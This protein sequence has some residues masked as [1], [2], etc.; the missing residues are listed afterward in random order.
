[1]D[2]QKPYL[3][4]KRTFLAYYY[5]LSMDNM[6][7]EQHSEGTPE[8]T[9]LVTP[10]QVTSKVPDGA[11]REG[12]SQQ[13]QS[14][15]VVQEQRMIGMSEDLLVAG[16]L[17]QVVPQ[18]TEYIKAVTVSRL[19]E[20]FWLNENL[21]DTSVKDIAKH[22]ERIVFILMGRRLGGITGQST[23][24]EGEAR[25]DL[26]MHFLKLGVLDPQDFEKA[27]FSFS[28]HD[29][30]AEAF[31]AHFLTRI[32]KSGL[33]W[34]RFRKNMHMESDANFSNEN[35]IFSH[36]DVLEKYGSV[37]GP[38]LRIVCSTD[39]H[40]LALLIAHGACNGGPGSPLAPLLE[41][42]SAHGDRVAF[43]SAPN[44]YRSN[45][46]RG[47]RCSQRIM[48]A[49]FYFAQAIL[50]NLGNLSDRYDPPHV[51]LEKEMKEKPEDKDGEG[52]KSRMR[53]LER[54][55]QHDGR[56]ARCVYGK[57][58]ELF[59]LL[60]AAL[61]SIRESPEWPD[62]KGAGQWNDTSVG[63]RL[64]AIDQAITKLDLSLE[65]WERA[66]R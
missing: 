60:P 27:I 64:E 66:E 20:L 34:P 47:V 45:W 7:S 15:E 32:M 2:V 1:M 21:N 14:L 49:T 48:D 57:G 11:V 52:K 3:L 44:P 18:A 37:D 29:G 9:A 65:H 33:P 42:E 46:D 10:G 4:D 28:G 16:R 25:I 59:E 40:I 5:P 13:T 26:L 51:R 62:R 39:Y 58:V 38:V 19:G 41:S 24:E 23:T 35:I 50:H 31:F 22:F 56:Y 43:L 61:K 53:K 30:E 63:A 6:S 8:S 55:Y 12:Q 36:D 54:S 17:A